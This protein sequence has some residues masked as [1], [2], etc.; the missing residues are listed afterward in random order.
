VFSTT[1]ALLR[2]SLLVIS[3]CSASTDRIAGKADKRWGSND[4]CGPNTQKVG[5]N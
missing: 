5:V 3:L 2:K 1:H 4:A